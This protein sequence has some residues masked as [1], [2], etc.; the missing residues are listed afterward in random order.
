MK[1]VNKGKFLA[2]IME[3]IIILGTV[4]ITPKAIIYANEW[5]GTTAYGG[6]YLIPVLGLIAILVIETILEER[7]VKKHARR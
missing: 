1:I 5:R 4:I 3:I 2:R 7:E 6:E